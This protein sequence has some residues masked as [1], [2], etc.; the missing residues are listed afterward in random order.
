MRIA[1]QPTDVRRAAALAGL[2]QALAAASLDACPTPFDR[3][4]Y[5]ERRRLAAREPLSP[6]EAADL[7][8]FV[9]PWARR[10]RSCP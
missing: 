1:D 8:A 10:L 2:C 7:A 6:D 3:A 4:C 9:G 5:A